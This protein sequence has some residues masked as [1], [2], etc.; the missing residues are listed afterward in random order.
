MERVLRSRDQVS[1]PNAAGQ[2]CTHAHA[3]CNAAAARAAAGSD[4]LPLVTEHA[5]SSEQ[6]VVL[7]CGAGVHS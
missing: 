2:Q 6:T 1:M 5:T 3:Y 4:F 7:M